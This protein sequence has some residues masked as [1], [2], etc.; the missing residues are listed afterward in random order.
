MDGVTV[1][2]GMVVALNKQ[3]SRKWRLSGAQINP[4]ETI[5]TAASCRGLS[6]AVDIVAGWMMVLQENK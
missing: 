3:L 1:L 4:G 5:T 2:G 6:S